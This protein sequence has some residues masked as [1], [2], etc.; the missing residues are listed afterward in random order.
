MTRKHEFSRVVEV[1]E[2]DDNLEES[3]AKR[4]PCCLVSSWGRVMA[5][6]QS[7]SLG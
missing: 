5:H 4:L 6:V 3:D 7:Q 2:E 1:D